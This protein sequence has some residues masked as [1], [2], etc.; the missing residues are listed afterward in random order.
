LVGRIG[1]GGSPGRTD[2]WRAPVAVRP[3]RSGAGREAG[4]AWTGADTCGRTGA[5]GAGDA[6]TIRGCPPGKEPWMTREGEPA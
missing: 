4:R 6:W 3:G 5:T 1:R 2:G